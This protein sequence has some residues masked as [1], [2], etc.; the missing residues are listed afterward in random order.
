MQAE[1]F[2]GMMLHIGIPLLDGMGGAWEIIRRPDQQIPIAMLAVSGIVA[3]NPG[4]F[5]QIRRS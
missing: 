5:E 3:I 2:A 1:M 4:L